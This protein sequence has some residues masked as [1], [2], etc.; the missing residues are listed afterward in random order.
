MTEFRW[1]VIDV[2][3]EPW[4]IG[5][6]SV[7]R[8]NG[9]VFPMVGRNNQLHDYKEAIKEALGE[10]HELIEGKVQLKFYFWRNRP[11]YR[12]PQGRTARKHEADV[13]NMQ[14]ATEDA[15]QG[16]LFKND[17]DTNDVHSVLVEQGPEVNGRVVIGI[18]PSTDVPD[19]MAELPQS[20]CELLDALD[21][22][23]GK[24]DLNWG[25]EENDR[26]F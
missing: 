14:K 23:T 3:P 24:S 25:A 19:V 13:T 17:K 15:L 20:V 16:I 21:K 6:L 11:P 18:R 10:H 12:T 7:G 1:F 26:L 5:D 4:A 22:P 9:K 2:N 8:R